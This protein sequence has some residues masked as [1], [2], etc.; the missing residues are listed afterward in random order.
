MD[1]GLKALRSLGHERQMEHFAG[2]DDRFQQ[3]RI[4]RRSFHDTKNG[5]FFLCHEEV[6]QIIRTLAK[7]TP[8]VG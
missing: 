2:V 3:D 1:G 5:R 4:S 6:G 8:K 7:I